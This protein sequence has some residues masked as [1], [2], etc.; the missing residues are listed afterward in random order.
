MSQNT[1]DFLVKG[2][3]TF[4]PTLRWGIEPLISVPI[5]AITQAAPARITAPG[6]GVPNGWP[7]AINGVTGMTQI[8]ATRYPPRGEDWQTAQVV[9]TNTVL[10]PEVSS[11]AYSAYLAGGF[12]VYR[13]PAPL[14][15]IVFALSIFSDP[16]RTPASLLT[17]LAN[18][19]GITVDPVAMTLTPL[20]QTEGLPWSQ[21]YYTLT[22][23]DPGTA[24]VTEL[25]DGVIELEWA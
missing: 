7:V 20:L 14:T 12:L 8:N 24:L 6:H 23:T 18:P 19:A 21:G 3:E 25:L 16:A 2:G 1:R 22:A 5:T 10:L 9:D 11:A 13:T 15:G 17:S 4:H